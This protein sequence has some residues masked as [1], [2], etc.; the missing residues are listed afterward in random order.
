MKVLYPHCF[1]AYPVKYLCGLLGIDDHET[2]STL[3]DLIQGKFSDFLV[4]PSTRF[5]LIS[6]LY[7][8]QVIEQPFYVWHEV[9][10]PREFQRT[11]VLVYQVQQ[12]LCGRA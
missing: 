2:A 5:A 12:G 6:H 7:T 8:L 10:V 1:P 4:G 9:I 11:F 3:P